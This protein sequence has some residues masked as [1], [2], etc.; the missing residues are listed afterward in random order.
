MQ[1]S[2][3]S[4]LFTFITG[5]SLPHEDAMGTVTGCKKMVQ[6]NKTRAFTVLLLYDRS[7]PY[8]IVAHII[9]DFWGFTQAISN[10]A[11]RPHFTLVYNIHI[12]KYKRIII[13]ITVQ[14]INLQVKAF[15]FYLLNTVEGYH[16]KT[17]P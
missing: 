10:H 2:E 13:M 15:L 16:I 4:E 12:Y 1:P 11:V 9:L 17:N 7:L 6:S 5:I 14:G 3:L 8:H